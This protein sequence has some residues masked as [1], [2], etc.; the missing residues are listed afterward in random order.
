MPVV[1]VSLNENLLDT[2]EEIE[3]ELGFSGRSEVVRSAI[4]SF[5]EEKKSISE[6]SGTVDCVVTA[7]HGEGDLDEVSDIE[8]RHEEVIKTRMHS[9]LD[10]HKCLQTFIVQGDANRVKEFWEALQTNSKVEKAIVTTM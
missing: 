1:S 6:L 8:H 9:H 2:L 7:T 4:R 10:N 5:I 3:K